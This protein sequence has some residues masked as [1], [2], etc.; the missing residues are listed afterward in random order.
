MSIRVV[1][2]LGYAIPMFAVGHVESAGVALT[3]AVFF[4]ALDTGTR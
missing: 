4:L 1:F 3:L 2:P